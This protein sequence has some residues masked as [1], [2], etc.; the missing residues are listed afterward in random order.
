MNSGL[1]NILLDPNHQPGRHF[2]IC[3]TSLITVWVQEKANPPP[4]PGILRRQQFPAQDRV[5][6]QSKTDQRSEMAVFTLSFP[7]E[8]VDGRTPRKA[9]G[10]ECS[11]SFL[12]KS[13]LGQLPSQPGSPP[14]TPLPRQPHV[15]ASPGSSSTQSTISPFVTQPL[16]YLIF[17]CGCLFVVR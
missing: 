6:V 12:T 1:R 5:R 2:P 17:V 10:G 3:P 11:N 4:S 8:V 16:A 7:P 9:E 14:V 15:A 13:S